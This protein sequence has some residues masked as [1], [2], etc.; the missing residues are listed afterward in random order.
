MINIPRIKRQVK[1]ELGTIKNDLLIL[2]DSREQNPTRQIFI[3]SFHRFGIK[4]EVVTLKTGDYSFVYKGVNFENK[5]SIDRKRNVSELVGNFMEDRFKKELIRGKEF[6]YFSF[7]VEFG[8]LADFY[9]GN[10]ISGMKKQS[11]LAILETMKNDYQVDF[12]QGMDFTSYLFTKIYYYLR[13]NLI[14]NKIK[15]LT[16][17]QPL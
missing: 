12:I 11:A 16:G 10:Y 3:E 13:S 8:R 2:I 5:F 15:T 17:N 7:C 4:S 9:E 6:E 1:K 14:K